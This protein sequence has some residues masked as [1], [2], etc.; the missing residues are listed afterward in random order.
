M[1]NF[2]AVGI[3]GA[4][5]S[6]LRYLISLVIRSHFPWATLIANLA[7]SAILGFLAGSVFF[8]SEVR[9]TIRL[10]LMVGFCGGFTTFSTF[11]FQTFD[12]L[13]NG[14]FLEAA[15]NIALNVAGCLIFTFLGYWLAKSMLSSF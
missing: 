10:M 7:G 8:M 6:M 1:N 9:P 13:Q 3:G 2:L 11:S 15:G 4:L 14:R 12:L 5:G